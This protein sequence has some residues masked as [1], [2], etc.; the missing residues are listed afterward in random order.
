[1]PSRK[2]LEAIIKLLTRTSDEI[3]LSATKPVGKT[4]TTNIITGNVEPI[5]PG[6]R[7]FDAPTINETVGIAEPRRNQFQEAL[8]EDSAAKRAEKSLIDPESQ[9]K[10]VFDETP[11]RFG[12]GQLEREVIKEVGPRDRVRGQITEE[13]G[14]IEQPRAK[15]QLDDLFGD[16]RDAQVREIQRILNAEG[17][18]TDRD[19]AGAVASEVVRKKT[20][21]QL[22][23]RVFAQ[24]DD[25][26]DAFSKGL[27]TT[28]S[29][30][31]RQA[32]GQAKQRMTALRK[33]AVDAKA[34][35]IKA[36][37][38][39]IL[40]TFLDQITGPLGRGLGQ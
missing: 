8:I 12:P 27:P 4:T 6:P 33:Q 37:D 35:A 15:E 7:P 36:N 29:Q 20:I 2:L 21:D 19:V 3:P 28:S 5:G 32:F 23:K 24:L 34:A 40:E 16:E 13:F 11:D 9:R 10:S 18:P 26:R 30:V 22:S 25:L 1:M 31:E 14:S 39:G 38:P 17:T